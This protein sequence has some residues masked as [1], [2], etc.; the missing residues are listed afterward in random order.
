L[1]TKPE[2]S[3]GLVNRHTVKEQL[4]YEVGDP[5]R[6]VTPDVVADM[7]SVQLTDCGPHRVLVAGGVGSPATST[8]K[9]VLS[10]P[11]GWSAAVGITYTYPG[12]LVKARRAVE[13]LDRRLE[14]CGVEVLERW[15][16]YIG[17]GGLF[18]EVDEALDPPEVVL[19]YAV[20]CPTAA[21]AGAVLNERLTGLSLAGPP[22]S[23][24]SG[25]GMSGPAPA[26]EIWPTLVPKALVDQNVSVVTEVL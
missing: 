21:E 26:S 19:R 16:E 15:T 8:Y 17:A 20:R 7:T 2:N 4:L 11:A 9:V 5:T 22:A 14:R 18:G 23:A 3:G 13:V 6:Y 12:A 25:V 10:R 24:A 1:L